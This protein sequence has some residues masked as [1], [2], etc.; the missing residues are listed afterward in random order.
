MLQ[1]VAIPVTVKCR[2]GIDADDSYEFF[3]GFITRIAAAGCQVFIIH[4]RKAILDGLSPKENRQVPPLKYDYVYKFK[5]E[6]PDLTLILNGGIN[7]LDQICEPLEKTDGIMVGRE[8][9]HNPYFIYEMTSRISDTSTEPP[10]RF[11]IM[12]Q[13]KEYLAVEMTQ[14]ESLQHGA[15]HLLG[16]FHGMPGARQFRRYLSEHIYDP[17]A[18]IDTITAAARVLPGTNFTASA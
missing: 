18:G 15:K 5:Q 4:A 17:N 6:R 13:Y 10:D 3:S 12:D 8:A 7:H 1:A 11:S 14:G 2:I 16:L 9:Y